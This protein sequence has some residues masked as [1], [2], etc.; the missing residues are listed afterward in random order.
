MTE[1]FETETEETESLS[2]DDGGEDLRSD[3]EAAFEAP[4]ETASETPAAPEEDAKQLKSEKVR[5]EKGRYSKADRNREAANVPAGEAQVSALENDASIPPPI[6]WTGDKKE[7]FKQLPRPLQEE[8]A[9]REVERERAFTQRSEELARYRRTYQDIDEAFEPHRQELDIAGVSPGQVVR[10]LLGM[11][12]WMQQEPKAAINHILASYNLTPADLAEQAQNAPQVD[13]RIHSLQEELEQ[14]KGYISTQQEREAYQSRASVDNEIHSFANEM[15][16]EGNLI[17]PYFNDVYHEMLP[18][19]QALKAANPDASHREI[20]DAAYD[21]AI[22][23]HPDVRM[24]VIGRATQE[25]QAKRINDAKAQAQKARVAG[26]SVKGSPGGSL[27]PVAP[28]DLRATIEQAFE[29]Y[30]L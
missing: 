25:T 19:A 18:I 3:L 14:L 10:Q 27:A 13:P 5:D 30:R 7:L 23:S 2:T 4:E 8:V 17:R 21:R 24:K 1:D 9:R 12:K 28:D 29:D 16:T 20:L 6:S 26:S 15:D 22:Y 11:Q